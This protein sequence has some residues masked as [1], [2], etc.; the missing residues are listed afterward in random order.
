[1]TRIPADK[2]RATLLRK[3][4]R[5]RGS[6]FFLTSSLRNLHSQT[7]RSSSPPWNLAPWGLCGVF[8]VAPGRRCARPGLSN[9][10]PFGACLPRAIPL[11][12]RAFGRAARWA[13]GALANQAQINS[14][15]RR[16]PSCS[17]RLSL[18]REH[19][20]GCRGRR[21]SSSGLLLVWPWIALLR[22]ERSAFRS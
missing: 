3:S 7:H 5:I 11:A 10:A 21:R 8:F 1:M 17:P 4:A 22:Q 18:C 16:S 9:L 20:Q 15:R 6:H 13:R 12:G 19:G 14:D 2:I